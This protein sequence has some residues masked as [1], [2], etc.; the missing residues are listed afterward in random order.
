VTLPV[1]DADPYEIPG[2][3][4]IPFVSTATNVIALYAAVVS[5]ASV[6]IAFLAYRAASPKVTTV[7][8]VTRERDEKQ[9]LHVT[10]ATEGSSATTV[11]IEGL[12][13]TGTWQFIQPEQR[14]FK[15]NL[16]GPALPHRMPGHHV[17]H[18]EAGLDSSAVTWHLSRELRPSDKPLV[19]V[20]IGSR[21]RQ[22]PVAFITEP[23]VFLGRNLPRGVS[24][25]EGQAEPDTEA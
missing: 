20:R 22:V 9:R 11:N 10:V 19:V 3:G 17:A 24:G 6:F 18:W 2:L 13:G 1:S 7:A 25:A 14:L 5:T 8:F 15:L 16:A 23:V 21:A 4:E 12:L